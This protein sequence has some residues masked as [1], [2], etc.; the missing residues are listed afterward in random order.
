[1]GISTHILD[2]AKGKPAARVSIVLERR[3][4]SGEFVEL[5]RGLTD[6]DGRQKTLLGDT[7]LTAG[8]HRLTF[9]TG[10]Y[11]AQSGERCFYPSVTVL[12]EILDP[13]Q[14]Y[15]VPILLSAY[16]YSTYRGS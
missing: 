8:V 5:G 13:A 9:D 15:H 12:F 11:F 14:H 2:T 6:N 3:E 10:G 1:M 16:G 4:A 7:A